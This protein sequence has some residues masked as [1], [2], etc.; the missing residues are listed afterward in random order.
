MPT[1]GNAL[2]I[3]KLLSIQNFAAKRIPQRIQYEH[4]AKE[5]FRRESPRIGAQQSAV[6]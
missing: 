4:A 3:E 2:C 5:M 1:F 6:W